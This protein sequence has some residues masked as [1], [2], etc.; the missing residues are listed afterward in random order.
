MNVSLSRF[1]KQ[2]FL[3]YWTS[4]IRFLR[5]HFATVQTNVLKYRNLATKWVQKNTVS[6]VDYVSLCPF[7]KFSQPLIDFKTLN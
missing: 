4:L 7:V 1:Y 6:L 3:P 5:P 2:Y